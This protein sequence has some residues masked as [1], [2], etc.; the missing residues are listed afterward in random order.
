MPVKPE[1]QIAMPARS[2]VEM[3][4]PSPLP[5]TPRFHEDFDAP[6]SEAIA[7]A[8]VTTLSTDGSTSPSSQHRPS[9]DAARLM[10]HKECTSTQSPQQWNEHVWHS[11]IR[12]RPAVNDRLRDWARKSIIM[13]RGGADDSEHHHHERPA[14]SKSSDSTSKSD[15]V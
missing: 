4:R 11:D 12:Q 2:S 14:S 3:Q 9:F 8:S 6:F 1:F 7:N 5:R 10:N 13:V 15:S